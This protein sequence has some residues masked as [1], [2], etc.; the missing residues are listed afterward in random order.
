MQ[1]HRISIQQ[2]YNTATK[3]VKF[4]MYEY[5][6]Q[7]RSLLNAAAAPTSLSFKDIVEKMVT[8]FFLYSYTYIQYNHMIYM[9]FVPY[10]PF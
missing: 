3:S 9:R 2:R 6:L 7:A 8:S 10:R 1:Y 4:N 5:V